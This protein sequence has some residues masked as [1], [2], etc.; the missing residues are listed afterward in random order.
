MRTVGAAPG[1]FLA[2]T[3]RWRDLSL[4][5]LVTGSRL[6][7]DYCRGFEK[8]WDGSRTG[9]RDPLVAPTASALQYPPA[10]ELCKVL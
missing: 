8:L 6:R 2:V 9:A 7:R 10:R 1:R 4:V 5:K 3:I